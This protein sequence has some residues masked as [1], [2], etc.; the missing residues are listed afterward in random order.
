MTFPLALSEPSKLGFAPGPL[1][2]LNHLIQSHIEEGHYPGAQIA[3]ARHGELALVR[4]YGKAALNP[5]RATSDDDLFLI[6]SVTKV[7][8]SAALWVLME[9][10]LVSISDKVSDHL[11]EFAAHGKGD[12]TLFQVATH[13]G[14]FPSADCSRASWVDHQLMRREVCDFSLDWTPGTR[15]VYH[16]RS[17]HFTLAMVI[18]AVTGQDYR[19]FIRERVI[20]PLGLESD[21]FM[22]V[23][24]PMQSRCADIHFPPDSKHRDNSPEFRE[25]GLP[26]L[27]AFA[28][29]RGMVAFY[30]MLANKGT[31]NGIRL[32]SPRLIEYATRNHT[33]EMPD[34]GIGMGGLPTHRGIG[35]HVRGHSSLIRGLG[36]LAHPETFGHG[37]VGSSY[38]WSD[39]ASGVSFAYITNYISPDPWHTARLDRISNIVHAAID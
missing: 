12:I 15:L 38:C 24:R 37:G 18:E 17:A 4:S 5:A 19:D 20:A 10:G 28:T 1:K 23:P 39:P 36:N 29:A 34:G 21:V 14:G 3:L 6:F 26:H 22:G 31:L 16:G 25:A 33:D 13:T 9:D 27:G 7:I 35:P 2:N 30:Q 8:T 11:P 32:F